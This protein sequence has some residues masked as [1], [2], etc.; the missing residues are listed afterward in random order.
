MRITSVTGTDLFGGSEGHPR[1]IIQ[2]TVL[3]DRPPPPGP[4]SGPVTVRVEG[5]G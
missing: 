4:A 2:V 5:P 1:Q 3:D